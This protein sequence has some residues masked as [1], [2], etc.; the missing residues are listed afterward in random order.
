MTFVVEPEQATNTLG[1][2]FTLYRVLD[3][4]RPSGVT[5]AETRY[6]EVAERL[7]EVLTSEQWSAPKGS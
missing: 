7:A 5:V 1:V 2:E 4:P 6:Q 3:R